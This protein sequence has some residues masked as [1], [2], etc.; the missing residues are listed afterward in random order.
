MTRSDIRFAIPS[1]GRLEKDSLTFMDACGL[2]VKRRNPRQYTATIRGLPNVTAL[3]Q[4]QNDIVRGVRQGTLDF[5]IV[6]LDALSE[7]CPK[8]QPELC[9]N[10]LIL[11]DALGI[12][13]C[14]LHLAIPNRWD[15]VNCLEDLRQKAAELNPL[16][17]ATKFPNLTD[18]FMRDNGIVPFQTVKADGTLE[19]APAIDYAD[20][21][22]DL[23]STG[24]TLKA[25]A[26]KQID[27][28]LILHSQGVLI[29]SK[30][31]L[32]ERPEVLETARVLLEYIAAH[33]RA[34]NSYTVTANVRGASP[35]AVSTMMLDKTHIR[36]L[37]GPTISKVVPHDP[38]DQAKNDW[39]AVNIIV[40]RRDLSAA[41]RELR[42]I[43]GSGVIVTEVKYIFEE[44]PVRYQAILEDLNA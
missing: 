32:K 7:R 38:A 23:V 42:E 39:Y 12:S 33:L 43:G 13:S 22:V 30:Q 41:I 14:E 36:G 10:I 18:Q 2:P 16:R 17:I 8:N 28:G 37:Q 4:R 44:E 34:K 29:G 27:D 5:A 11:H 24:T 15:D 1:N 31:A 6:G 19:I 35:E 20:I 26:L 3:W 40:Q 9:S 21:I 25:N